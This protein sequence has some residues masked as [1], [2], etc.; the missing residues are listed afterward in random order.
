MRL[1]FSGRMRPCQ[2]R[3]QGSIPCSRTKAKRPQAG[4]F[5]LLGMK[6]LCRLD[7]ASRIL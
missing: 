2:G 4:L 5:A 7:K 3:D 6:P 1:W